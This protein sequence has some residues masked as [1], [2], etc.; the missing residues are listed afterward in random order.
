MLGGTQSKEKASGMQVTDGDQMD[1]RQPRLVLRLNTGVGQAGR[2]FDAEI[3]NLSRNGMLV[4]TQADLSL[5]DPLEVVLPFS[6]AVGAKVVWGAN[7]LYGCSFAK[8]ISE[9]ELE[10]ANEVASLEDDPEHRFGV[11]HETLGTRIKRLRTT[12]GFTMC[13]L[14]ESVGVSKPTLWKWEGDQVRPRHETMQRLAKQLDVSELELVYGAPGLGK[15]V[16]LAEGGL[17]SGASLADLIR[18][19]RRRIAQAAGVDEASVEINI[20]WDAD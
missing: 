19:S 16:A 4:K 12:R 7:E 13:G 3:L 2:A 20:N 11:D 17:D 6:G 1:R 15:A 14:A 8:P 5:D 18:A 10:A 9:D